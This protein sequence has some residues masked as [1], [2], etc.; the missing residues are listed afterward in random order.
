VAYQKQGRLQEA[1]SE[2]EQ[3][4]QSK[5]LNRRTEMV[6]TYYHLGR[7]YHQLG[8]LQKSKGFYEKAVQMDA[9]LSHALGGLAVLYGA[10]GNTGTASVYLERALKADSKN[11]YVNFNMGLHYM[12]QGEMDRAEPHFRKAVVDEGLKGFAYL[13][14]GVISKQRGQL[15]QAST[16]L[17]ASAAANPKDVTPHLHLLEVY[18]AAGLERMSLQEGEILS[19]MIGR[20]EALFR[21]TVELILTKGDAGDV[22]LSGDIIIPILYQVLTKR[23]DAFKTQLSYLKKVLDKDSKIE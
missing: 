3:A 13:Y 22:C 19:E 18:H 11:P 10:E 9:N 20:D 21:Q 12:K 23:A 15:G 16:H 6:V 1:I 7:A 5:G 14:L 17:K 8:E 4:L 2:F